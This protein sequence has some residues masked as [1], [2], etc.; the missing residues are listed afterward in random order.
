M[1]ANISNEA[2]IIPKATVRG[3]AEK[4]PE[5][6]VDRINTESQENSGPPTKPRKIRRNETLH[7]KVLQGNKTICRRK[8][9]TYSIP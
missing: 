8:N 6:L 1:L 5:E 9:E 3:V 2:L 4:I 7:H